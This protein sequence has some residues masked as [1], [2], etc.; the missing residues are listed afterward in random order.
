MPA[1][2]C[3]LLSSSTRSFCQPS[4]GHFP[5][6]TLVLKSLLGLVLPW[7][8]ASSVKN[9]MGSNFLSKLPSYREPHSH[10]CCFSGPLRLLVHRA[11]SISLT[12]ISDPPISLNHQLIIYNTC[13]YCAIC[14]PFFRQTC[15]REMCATSTTSTFI[16][17]VFIRYHESRHSLHLSRTYYSH[18][19]H[20]FDRSFL[21]FD[22]GQ[23]CRVLRRKGLGQLFR[24]S[25]T[26]WNCNRQCCFFYVVDHR[27]SHPRRRQIASES[28]LEL[29]YI[30]HGR[31]HPLIHLDN[32]YNHR[33]CRKWCCKVIPHERTSACGNY[34]VPAPVS[35]R[36][37]NH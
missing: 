34:L 21:H 37:C 14:I 9:L 1:L 22:Q 28:S 29:R 17:T 23:R 2:A 19:I 10:E 20:D 13:I 4:S 36:V 11:H 24:T 12:S 35:L 3:D 32:I 33:D 5:S 30:R 31:S 16:G 6:R 25:A 15:C 26:S 27:V 18:S 7:H 8:L